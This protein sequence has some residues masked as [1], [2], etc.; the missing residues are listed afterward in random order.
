MKRN[1][2]LVSP[3]IPTTYWSYKYALPF[4]KKKALLPPLGL[5]TV[6]A[7]LPEEYELRL[8]DMNVAALQRQEV[9]WADMVFLSAMLVQKHSFEEVVALCRDCRTPVVAGG[10]YPTSS[11][12]KIEGVDH[13]VLDEAECT[14]PEFLRDLEQGQAAPIYR[15]EGKPPLSLT[16]LPRFDLV[17]VTLYESMPLQ[18]SR[19]CPFGCEFCDIIEMFGRKPRTKDPEQFLAEVDHLYNTGFRGSLF[20]VDDNFVGNKNKVKELLPHLASWQRAH[21]YPFTLSTEASI[22]LAQDQELLDLMVGAGFTMVFIGIET[23]DAKTLAMTHKTQNLREDVLESVIRIQKR[24]IEVSGGFIV[25]FDGESGDIF[26]RQRVF[27]QK[28]GIST[29]MVGLLIAL[30]NTQLY[31]RLSEEGRILTESRGNNTHDLELNFIP[32]MPKQELLRG[33]KWLL[34]E[35]YAPR[36]Y[37]QRSLTL[38]KR[39]AEGKQERVVTAQA[40]AAQAAA[41]GGID[42]DRITR[43]VRLRDAVALLRSLFRQGFSSYGYHYLRYLIRVLA[44]DASLFPQAVTLAVRGHHFIRITREIMRADAFRSM[45]QETLAILRR[46]IEF[47]TNTQMKIH[48]RDLEARI[49]PILLSVRRAYRGLSRGVQ[50]IVG[51]AFLDF[52]RRCQHLLQHTRP[53]YG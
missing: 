19:G 34:N 40:A 41:A 47:L 35:V 31:R 6:A 8:V 20:I 38:I 25:G 39:F 14:L 24:G 43:A 52:E 1:V 37:F 32:Q 33:Y 13:F 2:L 42:P 11:F 46:E 18:F 7:M 3:R 15:A 17:D 26:E 48:R 4:V 28:A 21:R 44:V 29:A 12:D 16:P 9:E 51:D 49:R 23:P 45:I 50:T 10:P 5:L 22:T 30:P 53:S 36:K 27:I